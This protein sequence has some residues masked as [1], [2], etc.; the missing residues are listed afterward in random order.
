MNKQ[1]L[2][3]NDLP[4]YG[5]VALSVMLP[6]LTHLGCRVCTLPTAL[7]SNTLD[8]GKFRILETTDYMKDTLVVWKELDFRFDAV[9]TGFVVSEEQ[10]ALAAAFCKECAAQGAKIFVDPIMGDEG[11]LYN[12]VTEET[13]AHLRA[14]TAV[15]DYVVPNYTEAAYLT[16]TPYQEGGMTR[17]E[18]E[19]LVGKLREMGAKSV[20]I[21]SALVDGCCVVVGYD[22]LREESFLLPFEEI[23]VR[24]PGTGDLFSAVLMGKVLTGESLAEST[25]KAMEVVRTM[26]EQNRDAPDKYCGLP[27][28][29]SLSLLDD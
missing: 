15:A 27:I 24:L 8:Y 9:A 3:I 16:N 4:G 6:V 7:V 17:T 20:I 19:I 25:Q 26:I 5:N 10:A 23:P 21:T 11:H 28:G 18:A 1:V 22:H 13:A 12:G 2:L 14:L 29:S